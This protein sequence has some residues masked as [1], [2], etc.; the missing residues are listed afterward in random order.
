MSLSDDGTAGGVEKI[1]RRIV[2][3][4]LPAV[5][6]DLL[7]SLPLESGDFYDRYLVAKRRSFTAQDFSEARLAAKALEKLIEE[8]PN[9]GLAYPPLVRL[10]NTDF[11]YTAFGSTGSKERA[12]ALKLMKNGLAADRSNAHAHSVLGF[13][14][15]WHGERALAGKCIKQAVVLNPYNHVRLQEAATAW[16]Y[17]GDFDTAL[18]LLER[19][20]ELNP[21]GDDSVYEDWGRLYLATGRYEDACMALSEVACGSVWAD[22]YL[23][24]CEIALGRAEGRDRLS[25]WQARVSRHWHSKQLPERDDLAAWI[26]RHHPFPKGNA[27]YFMAPVEAGL[28]SLGS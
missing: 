11:G 2:G 3:A 7:A 23:S 26:G 16:T 5:D 8:R 12:H 14:H 28:A 9:F 27:E 22:L 18:E 19:A 15:L 13:C 21:N 25:E 4:T 10:Y 1:V 20:V 24:A 17:L 6:E